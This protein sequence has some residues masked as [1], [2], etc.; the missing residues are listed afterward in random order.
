MTRRWWIGS[1]IVLA[2]IGLVAFGCGSM[3]SRSPAASTASESITNN[4]EAGVDEGGIVKAWG[5]FLVVLRRGR[6]F[7]V[8]LADHDLAPVC[9]VDAFPPG[10]DLGT[11]YDEMLI[12]DRNVVVVG[13]SYQVGGTEIGLFELDSQGCIRHVSTHFLHSNDYYSS[14]NYASRLVEG[15]LVFYMPHYLGSYRLEDGYIRTTATLPSV[16]RHGDR[17]WE[18]VI[19]MSD[20]HAPAP[21]SGT[22]ALHTVVTCDL[23]Q[24]DLDCTA[25]G[26]IGGFGRTFYVSPRAVYVWVHDGVHRDGQ[27]EGAAPAAVYRLP[28][29]GS[30]PGALA[31]W[32]VPT[33]QFSFKE[34]TDGNLNVLVRE[35]G[36]GDSMGGPEAS[37][38]GVALARIAGAAFAD[39]GLPAVDRASYTAL[40]APSDGRAFQNRFVGDYVL[41]G[42]GTSW[43]YADRG[44]RADLFVHAY[45]RQGEAAKLALPHGVDRIEAMGEDAVVIGTDG[46]SLHFT[47][48]ELDGTPRA[49]DRFVRAE[50]SQGELRSHGFFFL[51]S[52]LGKGVLGLPVRS[53][54]SAGFFHLY[55]GS[56]EVLYLSVDELRFA[57]LGALAS[58]DDDVDDD[59]QVSCVDWYGNA[60]P[61]F[62]RGRV[63]ALLGYEL[64]EGVV[65]RGRIVEV[66][67][68][69]L[70]ADLRT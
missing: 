10:S 12:H 19:T 17:A 63:F 20:M 3:T 14:R 32:G 61:I 53:N 1:A 45:A 69:H 33:D 38:G 62:Y 22:T 21:P 56:A 64:V 66:E 54:R 4:Q 28:L 60:R 52:G 57:R 18:P 25:Q 24:G 59:C 68:T 15:K 67:R 51:P 58:R 42:T 49:V 65:R 16:R 6:L 55:Q 13:Y 47:S 30:A 43:G 7:T 23:G 44:A 41:Y 35:T 46:D 27:D 34:D 40:P 29:D 36:F 2:G 50:A 37:S 11:W 9:M 39:R 31:A 48:I 70:I 8:R 5:D 26:I